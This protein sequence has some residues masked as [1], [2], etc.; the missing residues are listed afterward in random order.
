MKHSILPIKHFDPPILVSV[1]FPLTIYAQQW[2]GVWREVFLLLWR[3]G[4]WLRQ[5]LFTPRQKEWT[6]TGERTW[7]CVLYIPV[8][9][10][11]CLLMAELESFSVKVPVEMAS[12]SR[13]ALPSVKGIRLATFTD[14]PSIANVEQT[15]DDELET[16][17]LFHGSASLQLR[18]KWAFYEWQGVLEHYDY[19]IVIVVDD[20]LEGDG[21]VAPNSTRATKK[22][23]RTG[24]VGVAAVILPPDSPRCG[25]FKP[26]ATK[27]PCTFSSTEAECIGSQNW[28]V[29]SLAFLHAYGRQLA[30][31]DQCQ[32]VVTPEDT[33]KGYYDRQG[34]KY[35][36]HSM[37]LKVDGYEVPIHHLYQAMGKSTRTTPPSNT[38][39]LRRMLDSIEKWF[40][41]L[42]KLETNLIFHQPVSMCKK[43]PSNAMAFITALAMGGRMQRTYIKQQAV[44][45][46]QLSATFTQTRTLP[47]TKLSAMGQ[48]RGLMLVLHVHFKSAQIYYRS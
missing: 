48:R 31:I 17:S 40:E 5:G 37:P 33:T 24:V 27:V 46:M 16:Q 14:L 12:Q 41:D 36:G 8:N 1:K 25:Q 47:A 2:K 3:E 44:E 9:E 29:L 4:Q 43:F 11:I 28:A 38:F 15:G 21:N 22:T 19:W 10:S 32:L 30:D 42:P 6:S 7:V 34:L 39:V 13:S 20:R 18:I 23:A 45:D 26:S 35:F